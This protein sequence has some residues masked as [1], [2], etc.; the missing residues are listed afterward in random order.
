MASLQR[1]QSSASSSSM[2]ESRHSMFDMSCG[3]KQAMPAAGRQLDGRVSHHPLYLDSC[4]L[5]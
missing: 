5:A 2:P 4:F 3:R 1:L